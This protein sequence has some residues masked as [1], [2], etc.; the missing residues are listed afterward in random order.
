MN[1]GVSRPATADVGFILQGNVSHAQSAHVRETIEKLRRL[2]PGCQIVLS[3]WES[4]AANT[5]N[6]GAD[7]V[8]HSADPGAL[9]GIRIDNKEA[10][11]VN[12][13]IVST[14][15]G[16]AHCDREYAAKM[17]VDSRVVS[18]DFLS[19]YA[20][21]Q[22]PGRPE[23]LVVPSFFT[24]DPSMFEQVP[25]HVSD[26]FQFGSTQSL[27][28][29]WNCELMTPE[30]A[31]WYS[32]HNYASHSS[33]LDRRFNCLFAVE[34]HIARQYARKQRLPVPLYHNDMR[35]EIFA[36]HNAL[37]AQHFIVADLERIGFELPKYSWVQNSAFQSLNCVDFFDWL[38]LADAAGGTFISVQQRVLIE[39]RKQRKAVARLLYRLSRPFWRLMSRPTFKTAVNFLLRQLA[40]DRVIDRR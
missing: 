1:V 16:L 27:R 2:A 37:L 20:A 15:I 14:C 34:Q 38:D 30:E 31:T 12:R 26:W 5:E 18:L 10:N 11:N 36:A 29:Y 13:Q 28:T 21:Y 4:C 7:V 35:P 3:T 39:K 23:R 22:R 6:I 19:L 33:H 17:R 8:I 40:S 32:S 24:L 9:R 25:M